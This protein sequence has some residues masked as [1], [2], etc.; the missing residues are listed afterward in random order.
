[1]RRRIGNAR[2]TEKQR[3]NGPERRPQNHQ[4]EKS[5]DPGAVDC[6]HEQRDH[7]RRRV[8]GGDELAPGDNPD[9]GEIDGDVDQRHPQNADEDGAGDDPARVFDFVP[10]EANVVIAEVIVNADPRGRTQTEQEPEREFESF[11]RKVERQPGIEMQ[12]AGDDHRARGEQ[13]PDPQTHRDLADGSDPPV[14]QR[15]AKNAQTHDDGR[16]GRRKPVFGGDSGPQVVEILRK[17]DVTRGDFQRAAQYELPDEQECH[18]SPEG[19]PAKTVT[20]IDITSAGSGHRR[21]Q[22]APNQRVR[23]GDEHGQQPAHHRQ[24]PVERRHERGN[25]DER[26]D[27][28]HVR[29][30]QRRGLHQAEPAEQVWMLL[31]SVCGRAVHGVRWPY[32]VFAPNANANRRIGNEAVRAHLPNQH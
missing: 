11:R 13:G 5:G 23:D 24:R 7:R 32:S 19:F 28:D 3:E 31:G 12:G 6:F 8:R 18:H 21:A 1:M 20:Q 26:P 25:R 16:A 9:D 2:V 17:P 4:G 27:A 22:L 29:H 15:D 30:V 14:E 10:D